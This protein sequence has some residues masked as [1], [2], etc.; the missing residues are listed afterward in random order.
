MN[1]LIILVFAAVFLTLASAEVS[2]DV[3]M[4]KRGVPCRCDSDGPHVRGNTLTGTVW[5]FGCPSGWHKC[6][7]GSSTCCK[8]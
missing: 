4:A 3:N 6:Q 7:K 2:E 5:V 1:R 8:Q